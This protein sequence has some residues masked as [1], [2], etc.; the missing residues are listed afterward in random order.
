MLLES[1]NLENL[2]DLMSNLV[3][4][5]ASA[6]KNEKSLDTEKSLDEESHSVGRRNNKSEMWNNEKLPGLSNKNLNHSLK[7]SNPTKKS[8]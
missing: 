2:N 4:R 3:L 5:D 1:C 6:S 8:Y 7:S